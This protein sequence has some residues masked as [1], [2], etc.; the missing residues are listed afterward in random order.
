[1]IFDLDTISN[2]GNMVVY[3]W[4]KKIHVRVVGRISS[5]H[6]LGKVRSCLDFHFGSPAEK[7]QCHAG[8][9]AT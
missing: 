6:S 9:G 5:H 3:C 7:L 4:M 8:L 2:V 1:M